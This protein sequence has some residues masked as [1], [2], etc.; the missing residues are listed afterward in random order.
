MY[1]ASCKL[2][3][4]PPPPVLAPPGGSAGAT[5]L[6]SPAAP[7]RQMTRTWGVP[8]SL[9]D[10]QAAVDGSDESGRVWFAQ[11]ILGANTR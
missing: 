9:A 10:L 2:A 7:P 8:R 3:A 5:S 4:A 11:K 6:Q 1:W